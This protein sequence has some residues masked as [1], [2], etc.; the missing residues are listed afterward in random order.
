[1][2]KVA[3]AAAGAA[4]LAA[5]ACAALAQPGD[6]AGEQEVAHFDGDRDRGESSLGLRPA[7]GRA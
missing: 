3:L 7:A 6:Q 4:G 2:K 1:M 5:I